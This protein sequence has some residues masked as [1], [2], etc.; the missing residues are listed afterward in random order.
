MESRTTLLRLLTPQETADLLGRTTGTLA[1]WRATR[2][3]NL[4]FLKIGSCVMY[5]PDDVM[6][7]IAGRKRNSHAGV[8]DAQ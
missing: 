5:H 3:Y 1:V 2:R 8:N 6:A 4:S 7:F